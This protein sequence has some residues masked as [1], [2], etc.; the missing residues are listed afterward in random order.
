MLRFLRGVTSGDFDLLFRLMAME[1]ENVRT[2]GGAL[3]VI[4]G[5]GSGSFQLDQVDYD[6]LLER[7]IE[8]SSENGS[9]YGAQM[10]TPVATPEGQTDLKS[11]AP[12]LMR[13][14]E[15][16]VSQ[17]EWL[18]N[19]LEELDRASSATQYRAVLRDIMTSLKSTGDMKLPVY[20][21]IVLKHLGR[22]LLNG[23]PG[24]GAQTVRG[25][26]S[27]LAKPDV[28]EELAGQLTLRDQPERENIQA[29]FNEVKDISIPVL[30]RRLADEEEAFGRSS[31]LNTL[32]HYGEVIRPHLERWLRDDRWY[33][34][35]NALGLLQKVGG[36]RDS[37]NVRIF[38]EHPNSKVRLEALRFLY[39][40]PV[41]VDRS[42]MDRLLD[43]PDPEV[44]ARAV[45]ALGV[46][47]GSRGFK[48]LRSLARKPFLGEGN[49]P[50]REMA[51]KGI[52]RQGDRTSLSFLD[53]LLKK[54]SF[55]H[56]ARGERIRKAVVGALAEIGGNDIE[57]ILRKS[58]R[59]LKGEAHR[60]ADDFLRRKKAKLS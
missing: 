16:E 41:S 58:L 9:F 22:H 14:E 15:G 46:L 17:E 31:I 38:L 37:A 35:R 43:D 4:R 47:M 56:P 30:L 51:I 50:M 42:L 39:R 21:T 28:L 5:H 8:T 32:G 6:G 24:G 36:N 33:V 2:A 20:A 40:Y 59:N 57:K 53:G 44:H 45:Y 48:R 23:A 55:I 52:A 19:K 1:P 26:V 34:V 13:S 29:V 60:T 27:D 3:E 11:A 49:V 7:R 12:N 25:A 10:N 18:R 54:R